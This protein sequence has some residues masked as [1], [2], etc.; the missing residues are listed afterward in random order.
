MCHKRRCIF[1]A[2]SDDESAF[3]AG[4]AIPYKDIVKVVEME[5]AYATMLS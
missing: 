1:T 2:K 5:A 4:K 3:E